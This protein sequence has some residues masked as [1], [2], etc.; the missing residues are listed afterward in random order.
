MCLTQ[1]SSIILQVMSWVGFSLMTK[2]LLSWAFTLVGFLQMLDW[3][4]TK[5]KGYIKE[6]GDDYKKLRRKAMIPFIM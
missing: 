5:H 1:A 3:A 6:Y 4:V 2:I